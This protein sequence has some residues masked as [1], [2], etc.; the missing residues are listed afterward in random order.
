MAF[1]RV[2]QNVAVLMVVSLPFAAAAD[3]VPAASRRHREISEQLAASVNNLGLQN[4]LDLS[5]Y[6]PLS[7][8]R[9]PLLSKAH[10]AWGVSQALTPSYAR[11]GVW[12]EISPLSIVDVRVGVEP[13][14]YFGTFNSLMSFDS[15]R[16]PFDSKTRSSRGG[17]SAGAAGRVHVSPT[18]KLKAGP[19]V[20]VAGVDFEW[21]RSNAAGPLFYEPARDTLLRT[22]G[23]GLLSTSGVLLHE[24]DLGLGGSF[25]A[26]VIHQLTYVHK[27]PANRIQRLGAIVVRQFGERRLGLKHPRLIATLTYYLDDPSKR[28]E[29][30]AAVALAFKTTK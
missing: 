16:D 9:N 27:A 18:L 13:A 4:S 5:W 28:H 30:G 1:R 12:A 24:H 8:S 17:A 2:G 29:L 19:L 26:G 6:W 25:S 3:G 11:L 14:Q 23:D 20:A 15:Y 21:W 22:N 7:E 10:L